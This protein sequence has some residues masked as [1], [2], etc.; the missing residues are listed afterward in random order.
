MKTLVTIRLIVR[1]ISVADA[2]FILT[3]MNEPSW[4]RFIGDRGVITIDDAKNYS[5][6]SKDC[7]DEVLEVP[8][9]ASLVRPAF[10]FYLKE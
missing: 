10:E 3:L 5:Q 8:S 4:L 2:E 6:R 1:R 7:E 9:A